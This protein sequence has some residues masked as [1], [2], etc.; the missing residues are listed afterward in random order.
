MGDGECFCDPATGF[1]EYYCHGFISWISD[2]V[3]DF[4]GVFS[5]STVWSITDLFRYFFEYNCCGVTRYF[6][7]P[8]SFHG[9]GVE[10]AEAFEVASF[11][12]LCQVSFYEYSQV[13]FDVDY[14][15]VLWFEF[16]E[17]FVGEFFQYPA[18]FVECAVAATGRGFVC[19]ELVDL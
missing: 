16:G 19:K 6:C 4:L 2:A 13:L 1:S 14:F 10:T 11:R 8:G 15:D 5:C 7:V 9:P 3:D 18:V 12:V 17:V